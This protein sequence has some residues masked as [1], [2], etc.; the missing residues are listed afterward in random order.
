[1]QWLDGKRLSDFVVGAGHG[2]DDTPE[3]WR[4]DGEDDLLGTPE[5]AIASTTD[6]HL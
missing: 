5:N 6:F 1:M 2:M 4:D 3:G